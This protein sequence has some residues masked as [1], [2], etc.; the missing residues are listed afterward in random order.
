[1]PVLVSHNWGDWNVKQEEAWNLFRALE[2]SPKKVLYMGT[3]WENHGTPGGDY[4]KHVEMWMDHY[5]KGLDNGIDRLPS[6]VSQTSDY[7]G[8][9]GFKK[10]MPKT[11]PV[12]LIA[13]ESF[14]DD[15]YNWKLLP[16]EP[17]FFPGAPIGVAEF[18]SGGI[19]TES[20]MNH[21]SRNK[22]DW[23]WFE[24]PMLKRDVRIFGTPKVELWSTIYRTWIS[25]TPVLVDVDP[26]AHL[27][28]GNNHTT[29][30]DPN[31]I[32][33]GDT[34]QCTEPVVGVTRGFLDSRYRN[35][36]HK[37]VEV[38]PGKSF[39]STIVMKPQDYVFR[40]GHIIGLQIATEILEWH[41]PKAPAPCAAPDPNDPDQCAT[42][43]IDWT[44][45]QTRLLLPIVDAPRDLGDLFDLMHQHDDECVLVPPVCP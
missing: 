30:C 7:E 1:I 6:V 24:T 2:N 5:L 3:R 43:R 45:G 4:A 13:Q 29:Y 11:K 20:H 23:F 22:H 38:T 44:E 8:A 28:V 31:A 39:D 16:T 26:S 21:H 37:E 18:P 12:E 14:T 25:L 36:L 33:A 15:K 9:L 27:A 42:F 41:V 32:Q 10:G 19:N 35:G 17:V 34:N 40:K